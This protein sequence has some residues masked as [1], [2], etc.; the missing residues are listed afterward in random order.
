MNLFSRLV[1]ETLFQCTRKCPTCL[2]QTYQGKLRENTALPLEVFKK[3]IDDAED[4]NFNGATCLQFFNEPLLDPRIPQLAGYVKTKGFYPVYFS[5]NGDLLTNQLAQSLDGVLDKI[6]ISLYDNPEQKR[7]HYTTLFHKTTVIFAG[8]HI[9]THNSPRS[10]L[11]QLI[12]E[13][14]NLPCHNPKVRMIVCSNGKM[15]LCCEDINCEWSLGNVKTQTIKEL[16]HSTK[17]NS[18]IKTLS[19]VD[20]RLAYEYCKNCPRR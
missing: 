20:G 2:R 12:K 18:I 16:W 8:E 6:C 19:Y 3:V 13:N 5:T 14:L 17:H 9:T 11:A 7:K 1:I 4:L 10:D 15:S